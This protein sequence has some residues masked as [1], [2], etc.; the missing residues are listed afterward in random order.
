MTESLLPA[1]GQ[2]RALLIDGP[3]GPLD[4]LLSAPREL[5]APA[6]VAVICHPHPLH[7]GEM[8][9]KVT[10]TLASCAQKAGC[11]A[12][13]FNFRGTGRSGGTHDHGRG[14]TE[15]TVFL[16]RWLQQQVPGGRLL[17]AGFS[18]GAWVST[19]AA[20]QLAPAA[21]VSIAPPFAKYFGDAPL[22]QR[23][24]CP[25]LVVHDR[26]DDVVDYG[27]TV[28]LLE[29][30]FDPPPQLVSTEGAGHF[31]HGRLGELGAAV[32]SFLA[33]QLAR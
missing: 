17:L 24:D 13:R 22:P 15:D 26:D 14:E 8:N 10:Y 25:W 4:V 29:S 19:N 32:S 18:F 2:S 6:D 5:T 23:P 9:N 1:P 3:A 20:A 11:Y 33:T 28:A 7:G 21:V 31:F 16:A 12:L 27:E 30:R